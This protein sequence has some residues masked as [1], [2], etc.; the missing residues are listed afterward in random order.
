MRRVKLYYLLRV[1]LSALALACFGGLILLADSYAQEVFDVLLIAMGIFGV[2][3]NLPAFVISLQAVIGRELW[4]W[5]SL[6]VSLVGMLLGVALILL[7][8]ESAIMPIL[9]VLYSVLLPACKIALVEEKKKQLV[10]ELPKVALGLLVLIVTLTR[11]EDT[12]F[13]LMG[14]ACIG[15]A[16]LYLLWRLI[17][18]RSYLNAC[19]GNDSYNS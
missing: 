19:Q 8:R 9:L 11:S 14:R 17:T 7:Q 3:G 2:I 18:M 16:V 4:K 5:I 12:V 13:F 15:I 6:S 10:L 1:L